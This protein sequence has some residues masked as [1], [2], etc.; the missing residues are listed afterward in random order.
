MIDLPEPPKL[1][2]VP[3]HEAHA[4][5]TAMLFNNKLWHA[6]I[7]ECRRLFIGREAEDWPMGILA[8]V[9]FVPHQGFESEEA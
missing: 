2:E 5:R 1:V 6:H 4:M 7:R 3:W 8:H 9:E